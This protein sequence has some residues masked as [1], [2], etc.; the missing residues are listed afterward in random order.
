MDEV[1]GTVMTILKALATLV[2]D[3]VGLIKLA[4]AGG[5]SDHPL[6]PQIKELFADKDPLDKFLDDHA[7]DKPA[8]PTV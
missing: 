5:D 6:Y 3:L 7:K 1:L 4:V 8:D 2:P